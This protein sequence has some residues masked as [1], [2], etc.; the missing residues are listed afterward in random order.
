VSNSTINS[1]YDTVAAL[2]G[3][4]AHNPNLLVTN[5]KND[6]A[7]LTSSHVLKTFTELQLMT[8]LDEQ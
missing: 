7:S 3:A 6:P 4:M 1:P 5:L 8:F 2:A